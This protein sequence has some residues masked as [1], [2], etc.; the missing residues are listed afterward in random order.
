MDKF[1]KLKERIQKRENERE[2]IKELNKG[3]VQTK[4]V[5]NEIGKVQTTFRYRVATLTKIIEER[6][7]N[8]RLVNKVGIKPSSKTPGAKKEDVSNN[9]QADV[10]FS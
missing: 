4:P 1:A 10:L 7:K 2:K 8:G 5:E 6:V 3:S 9:N